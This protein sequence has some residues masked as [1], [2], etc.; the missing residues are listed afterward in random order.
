MMKERARDWKNLN[1]MDL[2]KDNS[3]LQD[4]KKEKKE[5]KEMRE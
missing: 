5:E 3:N 2:R 1:Q 4:K